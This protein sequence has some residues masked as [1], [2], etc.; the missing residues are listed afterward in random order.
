M[1][2]IFPTSPLPVVKI[3]ELLLPP[4]VLFSSIISISI[5]SYKYINITMGSIDKPPNFLVVV[6]D[7]LGFSD[8]GPFGSEI[9]TPTLDKLAKDGVR[10]T[11][12]HTASAC[13]PTR[14]MLFSGTDNHIAGLGQM[15]EHM[16]NRELFQG[17]EGYEGYLNF[18]VAAL[19]EILQD[20]GY[21]T[22]MSGKWYVLPEGSSWKD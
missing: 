9:Q 18:K 12:F 8:I 19:P 14:A 20:K 1:A 3:G 16:S 2:Y 5:H 4:P 21:L 11:N 13:S 6:A 17:K 15:A 10:L 7:D 22:M